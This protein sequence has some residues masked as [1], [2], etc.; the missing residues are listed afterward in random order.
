M[1]WHKYPDEKP[2]DEEVKYII[3]ASGRIGNIGYDHAV[4]AGDNYYEE[5][6]W[7][8]GGCHRPDVKVLAWME[9]PEPYQEE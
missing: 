6:K 4:L 5:G 1:E 2:K 9:L 8:I 7:Y 3:C